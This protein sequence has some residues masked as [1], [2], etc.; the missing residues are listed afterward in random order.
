MKDAR[1]R[2][3]LLSLRDGCERLGPPTAQVPGIGNSVTDRLIRITTALAVLA[4]AGVA[5]VICCQHAYELVL[6][7]VNL[8]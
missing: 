1:V 3:R 8:E 7:M 5:A 2:C 4:T 6:R